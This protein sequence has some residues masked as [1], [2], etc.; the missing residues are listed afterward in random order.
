MTRRSC[1]VEFNRITYIVSLAELLLILIWGKTFPPNNPSSSSHYIYNIVRRLWDQ[2]ITVLQ[3]VILSVHFGKVIYNSQKLFLWESSIASCFPAY[4]HQHKILLVIGIVSIR[5]TNIIIS[6]KVDSFE[7]ETCQF[8]FCS[9]KIV[10]L[11]V[12]REWK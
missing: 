2:V 12:L 6:L 10:V 1:I 5:F 8:F 3:H 9:F 7:K 4:F 11:R